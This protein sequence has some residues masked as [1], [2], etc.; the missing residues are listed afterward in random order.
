M[1]MIKYVRIALI[2]IA[3]FNICSCQPTDDNT[4]LNQSQKSITIRLNYDLG[5]FYTSKT[6]MASLGDMEVKYLLG[7]ENGTIVHDLMSTYNAANNT[8]VIEPLAKGDYKLFVLA[9]TKTLED[10][11]LVV[12]E[13]ISS[14]H[15]QWFELPNDA[16]FTS[17]NEY[18][19][20]GMLDVV[21]DAKPEVNYNLQ[22]SHVL[23]AVELDIDLS[24]QYL[25]ASITSID[26][27]M[28]HS[29][30]FYSGFSVDGGYCG[31]SVWGDNI[32]PV[33]D[34]ELVMLM[35]A[36]SEQPVETKLTLYTTNHN[37]LSYVSHYLFK[38][39]LVKGV[40]NKVDVA[41]SNHPD[42]NTATLR[43]D[44]AFLEDYPQTKLLQDDESKSIYYDNN[45]RSFYVNQP[46]Q[47]KELSDGLINI[48]SYLP[49]PVQRV[50]FWAKLPSLSQ[51]ILLAYCDSVPAFSDVRLNMPDYSED[52]EFSTPNG[53]FVCLNSKQLEEIKSDDVVIRV[54]SEDDIW[55]KIEQ[56]KPNWYIR[57]N[58]FGGDPDMDN[59]APAGNWMGIRPVHIR[60]AIAFLTNFAYMISTDEFVG[61]LLTFQGQINDNNG[62]ELDL[63]KVPAQFINHGGFN[64]GLVYTGNGVAGLGGGSTW[65]VS[66]GTYL[67]QYTSTY[68]ASIMFHE[69]GH[70]IGYSH[71]SGMSYG[72]WAEQCANK[73]YVSNLSQLIVTSADVVN[74]KG[75]P[76]LY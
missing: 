51:E 11:G 45:E 49:L 75:N 71:S 42:A 68:S 69:L 15:Q 60:E 9:Y 21:V 55:R 20:Y 7:N 27:S 43:I 4:Y 72:P 24:N 48:R 67:G 46:L 61:H 47:I 62:D 12:K 30:T 32:L 37:Q 36:V 56:M 54:E 5:S 64:V 59:G 10:R 65:G 28:T 40:R 31:A 52:S 19:C 13:N 41:F 34:Q 70:C 33:K 2:F 6:R 25:A 66:Q 63:S 74:S 39:T 73:Y 58:A 3:V 14:I 76:C 8:I 17:F 26:W 53:T 22:L 1:K 50:E 44:R 38:T 29:S 16:P 35:P 18:I 23:A 57:F